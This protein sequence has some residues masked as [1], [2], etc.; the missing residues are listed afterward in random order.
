[1]LYPKDSGFLGN[2]GLVKE[3]ALGL[4]PRWAPDG[5]Y[6]WLGNSGGPRSGSGQWQKSFHLREPGRGQQ[7]TRRNGAQAPSP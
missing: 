7:K 5:L 3:Q 1:M 4:T 6:C 2:N